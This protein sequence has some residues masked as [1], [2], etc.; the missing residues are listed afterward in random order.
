M[1][2]LFGK[3]KSENEVTQSIDDMMETLTDVAQDC[4]ISA[5]N[6]IKIWDI[7]I[8]TNSKIK[9]TCSNTQE[10]KGVTSC[11]QDAS[12]KNSLDAQLAQQAA[13]SAAAIGTSFQLSS[14]TSK[15]ISELY[16]KLAQTISNTFTQ[17]CTSVGTN[18]YVDVRLA[19][20]GGVV[21]KDCDV[22]QVIDLTTDCV[23][24]SKAVNDIKNQIIQ[25]IDQDANAETKSILGWLTAIAIAVV[26]VV[27]AVVA[28]VFL[29]LAFGVVG[30]K[31]KN[32][33]KE[34]TGAGD[35]V[36]A[37]TSLAKMLA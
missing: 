7:A 13:Q 37:V 24:K 2:F 19:A 5:I 15:N 17:T 18:A 27:V 36:A 31:G 1:S 3:T 35:S 26:V 30:G 9:D 12:V 8:G 29:L 23:Q 34:G 32:K 6:S 25:D 28:L 11:G 16:S 14:T 22:S 4:S 10:I 20:K 21:D 33:G